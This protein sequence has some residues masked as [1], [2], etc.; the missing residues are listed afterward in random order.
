MMK[1][2]EMSY[3]GYISYF[4]GTKFLRNGRG[5]ILHQRKHVKE[6]LRRFNK[7]K[8]IPATSPTEANM[9]L[10]KNRDEDKV[11]ATLL[12]Q[13]VGSLR[14]LCN[15]RPA[16]GFVIGLIRRYIDDLK[17]SHM[18]VARRILRYLNGTVN[19][20]LLFPR[21]IGDDDAIITCYSDSY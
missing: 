17:V 16:I 20:G 4:L 7:L 10:E 3:L 5:M 21:N 1:E 15:S 6:V 2:F 13:I 12:K 11:N 14:Y 8:F 9:K 18:K 19:C